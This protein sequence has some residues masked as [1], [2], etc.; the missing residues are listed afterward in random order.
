MIS[1]T[2]AQ[3]PSFSTTP[4]AL[5]F[6]EELLLCPD[7]V[8]REKRTQNPFLH[9]NDPFDAAQRSCRRD[10]RKSSKQ[11]QAQFALDISGFVMFSLEAFEAGHQ[12][13]DF[14][15]QRSGIVVSERARDHDGSR[16]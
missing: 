13:V 15:G 14:V 10:D 9:G 8:N 7:E 12:G 16:Q 4:T 6:L 11:G 2:T 5:T 1:W 3:F